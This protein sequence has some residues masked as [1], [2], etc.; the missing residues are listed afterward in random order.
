MTADPAASPLDHLPA[1]Q[2]VPSLVEILGPDRVHVLKGLTYKQQ[3]F[4]EEYGVD[5][6][7]TQACIRAG[8]SRNSAKDQ[9]YEN[10]RKPAIVDAITAVLADRSEKTTVNRSWVMAQLVDVHEQT[11]IETSA[12]Q[13]AIRLRA[14]EMIGK[15]VDVRA[16]RAGLGFSNDGLDDDGRSI[17][18]LSK[19]SDGP[20]SSD[21]NGLSEFEVF[22]RL[23]AKISIVGPH[24][25]GAGGEAPAEAFGE[26]SVSP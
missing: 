9:G 19:L 18:D 6:N 22:E 4:V 2:L 7:A 8:Y 14:L 3:R 26:D 23:L 20:L 13:R 24:A 11:K 16:F 25:G 1:E 15:H 10:L 17:W 21:Y 5:L 12:A